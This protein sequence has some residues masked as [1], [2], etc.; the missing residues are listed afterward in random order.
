ML[1][2]DEE[3]ENPFLDKLL[4]EPRNVRANE[5]ERCKNLDTKSE[6]E[7]PLSATD[8]FRFFLGVLTDTVSSGA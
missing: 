2:V 8:T 3:A 6:L 4:L 1:G 5:V 7:V